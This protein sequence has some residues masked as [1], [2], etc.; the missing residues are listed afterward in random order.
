[1]PLELAALAVSAALGAW[2]F[3]LRKIDAN[4]KRLDAIELK[5]CQEYMQKDDLHREFDRI[6]SIWVR[7]IDR[8]NTK[9]TNLNHD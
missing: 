1:M 8:I 4:E 3:C 2:G 7:E 9:F 5:M 6:E